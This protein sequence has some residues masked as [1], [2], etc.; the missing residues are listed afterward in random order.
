MKTATTDLETLAIDFVNDH[1]AAWVPVEDLISRLS[2][3]NGIGNL[4]AGHLIQ[5]LIDD[6]TFEVLGAKYPK[7]RVSA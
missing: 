4:K 5:R 3:R 1:T 2:R 7:V 6:G